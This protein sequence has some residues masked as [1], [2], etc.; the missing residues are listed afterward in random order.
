M[1]VEYKG[2]VERG[3]FQGMRKRRKDTENFCLA[4]ET[5]TVPKT[6]LFQNISLFIYSFLYSVIHSSYK[7][8]IEHLL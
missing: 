8:F 2:F 6:F 7:V 5:N 4:A 3:G 1:S